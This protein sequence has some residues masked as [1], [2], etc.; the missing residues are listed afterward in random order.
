MKSKY[1]HIYDY[2]SKRMFCVWVES[3]RYS[4]LRMMNGFLINLEK[5][6]LIETKPEENWD[7]INERQDREFRGEKPDHDKAMDEI[8]WVEEKIEEVPE[9]KAPYISKSWWLLKE[10]DSDS[11]RMERIIT[12]LNAVIKKINNL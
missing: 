6:E 9:Y 7:E 3:E 5:A 4:E 12:S 1:Y 8:H 10:Y 11:L 2:L